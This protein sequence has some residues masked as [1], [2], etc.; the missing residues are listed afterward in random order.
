MRAAAPAP[1]RVTRI[2]TAS[3]PAEA[4]IAGQRLGAQQVARHGFTRPAELVAW[5]GAVQAQE[6]LAARWAVGLRL[7]KGAGGGA[8]NAIADALADGS[9]LRTHVMRWTWQLVTPADLHWMLPLVAP[10]LMARAAR[11]QRELALDA[12]T[13]RKAAAACRASPRRRLPM[14]ISCPRSTST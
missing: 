7:G 6:P 14:H 1:R 3:A 11:R 12:R 13:F 9:I 8:A 4:L 5:M 10:R 2:A